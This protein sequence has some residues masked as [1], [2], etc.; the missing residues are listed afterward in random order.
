MNNLKWKLKALKLMFLRKLVKKY[1]QVIDNKSI[2][3]KDDKV[4]FERSLV[5]LLKKFK[6]I[7]STTRI[8]HLE[9]VADANDLPKIKIETLII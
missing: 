2:K 1:G 9:I 4:K 7:D 5:R 3:D 8:Q 6:I